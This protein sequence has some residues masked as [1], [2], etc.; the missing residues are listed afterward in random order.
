MSDL[1]ERFL[2]CFD[3]AADDAGLP[4]DPAFRA[5][6]HAYMRWAVDEVLSYPDKD[7][8][9]APGAPMPRWGWDGLVSR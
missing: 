6:L 8:V 2:D 5:A 7:A 1:G 9:V 4:A 3:R